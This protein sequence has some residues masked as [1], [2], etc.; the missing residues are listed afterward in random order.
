MQ[1]AY[2]NIKDS[3][4][5]RWDQKSDPGGDAVKKCMKPTAPPRM[6]VIIY[7]L[8]FPLDRK[9]ELDWAEEEEGRK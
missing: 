6:V 4:N 1:A 2:N 8:R 3:S 5:R 9:L 7:S